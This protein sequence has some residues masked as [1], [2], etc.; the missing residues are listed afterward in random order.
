MRDLT[1][2]PIAG[3]V[4]AMALPI[5]VGM[6]V[7]TLYYLV[8]LYFVS[9]LGGVAI[10]GVSAAGNLM[11]LVMALTQMLSVGTMTAVSHAVGADDRPRANLVFNQAV[12]LAGVLAAGALLGG[13]GGL[14]DLYIGAIS[15]DA[16]TAAAGTSYL[17]WFMPAMA[18]QF[19][20][21]AMAAALQGTGIVKPT[22]IVQMLAVLVNIVLTPIL[23]AGWLTGQ[24]MGVAGAGLASSLAAATGLLL[25]TAYFVRLETYVG[26]H[27]RLLRPRFEVL[28][29]MLRVGIPA[30]GEFALMFVYMAVIY[31][32]I[33]GFGATAQAG[34]GIGVRMMQAVFL[35]ALAIAF[36]T[37]A[38]AGQNFGAKK[39]GRVRRTFRTAALMN[40][41]FMATL[42]LFCQ[43]RPQWLV[44]SFTDDPEVL[45][46][47][48]TFM[49]VV[50]WNF[51][52][53]GLTFN[54]SAMFQGMGNTLPALA[55]TATRLVTFV[56]PAF[57]LS[58]RPGFEIEHV[59]YLSVATVTVQALVALALL[60]WQ[61]RRRLQF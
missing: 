27:S 38:I 26:L 25:M 3:H 7:Q 46:V 36:A 44:S 2:G 16:S 23:V 19:A 41:V 51:V 6:L 18:L 31:A 55:S 54:C 13:Y 34:F 8:D 58:R 10:A 39:A 35:P 15:A 49:T 50:S 29:N 1:R 33:S 57:W 61:F 5:A 60:R 22:M 48:A 24:P 21:T 59:W 20:M 32:V 52:A 53:S 45:A 47:A 4:A 30:G 56:G 9:R 43:W 12:L 17:R 14:G 42:T 37:P 40:L 11:F 28:E